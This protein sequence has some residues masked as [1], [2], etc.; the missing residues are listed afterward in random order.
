[1]NR[2]AMTNVIFLALLAMGKIFRYFN[3]ARGMAHPGWASLICLFFKFLDA[4]SGFTSK[5]W[6]FKK[7]ILRKEQLFA[8]NL[9]I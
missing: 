7:K 8:I 5:K 1:L 2:E 9:R 6:N 3:F 4:V